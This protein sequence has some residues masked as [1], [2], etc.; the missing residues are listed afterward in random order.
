MKVGLYY[1]SSALSSANLQNVTGAGSGYQFG[2]LDG[3]RQFVPLGVSTAETKLT[4]LRD[5]NMV[6]DS[7]VNC[8]TP[9]S[10]GTIVVG[11]YHVQLNTSYATFASAQAAAAAYVKSFVKYSCGSFYVCI[12]EFISQDE[13]AS[14]ITANSIQNAAV[15][16]GTSNTVTVVKTGTDTILFEFENGTTSYLVIFPLSSG[17]AKCQTWFKGYKYYGGFQ[18]SRPS[19]GDL[20]V[21]NCV[22]I[23]DY[24]KGVIPYEMSNT[25][26]VEALKAQAVCAR[27]YVLANIGKHSGFDVCTTEDCQVYRGVSLSNATTD[28]AVDQTAGKYLTYNGQLCVAFYSSCDGGAT[29]NSENVWAS[30]VPYLR[31]VADPYEKNITSI[32]SGYYWTVTYTS[33]SITQRLRSKGYNCSTIVSMAVTQTTAVGNVYKVTLTDDTGKTFTFTKGESVRSALGVSSIHFTITTSGSDDLYV[34]GSGSVLTGEQETYYAVG[35]SGVPA[36]LGQGQLYAVDGSGSTVPVGGESTDKTFVISGAGKGHNVGMSQWGAYSMA[37]YYG[38]T[39][40]Q[41]LTFYFTG[42][43]V[44]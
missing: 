20:T 4:V 40:D 27:T 2:T 14:Y 18:Y 32:A 28:A 10:A 34:N 41:I 17:G 36:L 11:C 21:I 35:G 19:G 43:T 8:Y 9:G 30:A 3:S 33:S 12:G 15:T 16:S 23:E 38:K 22:N 7:A 29:E 26:P 24:T 13:A 42:V 44:G 5:R 39:Y 1:G 37:K 25:W 31:G 6:Y